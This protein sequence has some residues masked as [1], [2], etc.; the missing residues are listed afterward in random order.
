M[1]YNAM[2]RANNQRREVRAQTIIRILS[3]LLRGSPVIRALGYLS[4]TPAFTVCTSS[5]RPQHGKS[6]NNHAGITAL[7]GCRK[8]RGPRDLVI[9]MTHILLYVHR[10]CALFL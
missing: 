5:T 3:N 1:R 10:R 2:L 9:S 7:D 6:E 8:C 4:S